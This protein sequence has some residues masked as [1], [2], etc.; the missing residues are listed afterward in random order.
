MKTTDLTSGLNRRA[1]LGRALLGSAAAAVMA[2]YESAAAPATPRGNTPPGGPLIMVSDGKNVAETSA[3]KVRGNNHSGIVTF[4]GIPYGAPVGGS[5]RFLPLSKPA[6]WTGVRSA[7]YYGP[8]SPQ[9]PRAGWANDED[10]FM[11][12]WDDGQPGEDCL[13]INVWTP[14]LDSRKRPVMVWLHGGGFSAGSGQELKA[15]EGEALA[16]R[17]GCRRK[18]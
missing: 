6:P 3:G 8:V 5:A 9:G 13:R 17:R 4:K 11:F 14:A 16:R 10:S 12:E 18:T 15:Y 1:L 2:E 7:L